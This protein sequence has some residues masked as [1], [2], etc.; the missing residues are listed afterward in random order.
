VSGILNDPLPQRI[1]QAVSTAG[2]AAAFLLGS[3]LLGVLAGVV[4]WAVTPLPTFTVDEAGNANASQRDLTTMVAADAWYTSLGLTAGLVI[5]LVAW[6]LFRDNGWGVAILVLVA[7]FGAG[8]LCWWTGHRLGPDDFAARLAQARGGAVVE[9]ELTLVA[10]VA[11]M[12]WPFAA[13]LP[14]LLGA[15]LSTDPEAGGSDLPE[16]PGRAAS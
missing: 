16:P 4:W 2:R 10:R 15:S 8:L 6:R 14:V 9:V 1:E 5:G 7:G 3:S 11:L 12:T 13:M